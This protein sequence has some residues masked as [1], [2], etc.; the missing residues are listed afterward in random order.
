MTAFRVPEGLLIRVATK[1]S[2]LFLVRN[3]VSTRFLWGKSRVEW[4]AQQDLNLRP[5]DYES[6]ALTN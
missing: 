6:D 3:A 5:T 1:A 4:W 2:V